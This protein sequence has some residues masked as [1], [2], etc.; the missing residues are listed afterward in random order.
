MP[1]ADQYALV[2]RLPGLPFQVCDASARLLDQQQTSRH[3]PRF[4]ADVKISV[5][6]AGGD[7]AQAQRRRPQPA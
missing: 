1:V 7:V 4:Q 5:N 3:V 6:P 2:P